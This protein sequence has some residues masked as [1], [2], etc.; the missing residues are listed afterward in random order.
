MESWWVDYDGA[1]EWCA[2]HGHEGNAGDPLPDG[3][4]GEVALAIEEDR[5]AF[6]ERV[7][8]FA[9]AIAMKKVFPDDAT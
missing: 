8:A 7:K 5:E 4:S 1:A 3:L 2:Q 9:Y 6:Q